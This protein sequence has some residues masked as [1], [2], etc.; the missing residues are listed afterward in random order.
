MP[1]VKVNGVELF[2]KESGRG[3]ETIVFSHGLLMDH[4]MFEAQRAAFEGNYRVIAYDHRGQG[5]SGRPKEAG[6]VPKLDMETLTTDAAALIQALDAVPCHFA[7]LS[8]G[9]FIGM[10]LAARRPVLVR[11]LTLMNTGADKEP[12]LGRLR[13]GFLARL[14]LLVEVAPF[15]GIAMNALFGETTRHDPAKRPMLEEW[16]QKLRQRPRSVADALA[17]VMNRSEVTPG[18]LGSIACPALIIAGEDD[19]ARPPH[20]S[21][22]LSSLIPGSRLVRIPGAGHSS[23][24]ESPQ[25]VIQAMRELMESGDQLIGARKASQ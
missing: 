19:T 1:R 16:R 2:Y 24:L 9:G 22:R 8:M 12:W 11:S 6:S 18:E 13:Y 10:R 3:P 14:V 4:S 25:A 5:Q 7:G 21:E 23:A 15:T 17:A 20:D